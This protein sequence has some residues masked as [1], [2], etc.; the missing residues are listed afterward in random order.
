M[1]NPERLEKI[2][3]GAGYSWN[4]YADGYT[5]FYKGETVM[6]V[7]LAPRVMT[8]AAMETSRKMFGRHAFEAAVEDAKKRGIIDE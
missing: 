2:L 4:Y 3:L 7:A 1:N 5:V 8:K 6:S